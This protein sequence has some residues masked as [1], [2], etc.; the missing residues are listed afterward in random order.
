MSAPIKADPQPTNPKV[1]ELVKQ[2]GSIQLMREKD[3]ERK[4]Q[5]EREVH[6]LIVKQPTKASITNT[7]NK[8]EQVV[9]A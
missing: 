4:T 8:Q 5:R 3:L 1:S 7:H 6:D 9:G 2:I